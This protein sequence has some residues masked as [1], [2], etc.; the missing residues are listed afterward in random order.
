MTR[1]E[2]LYVP[3]IQRRNEVSAATTTVSVVG[4]TKGRHAHTSHASEAYSRVAWGS[5]Y[6]FLVSGGIRCLR[7]LAYVTKALRFDD[8]AD[9]DDDD[10]DGPLTT[11]LLLLAAVVTVGLSFVD[12]PYGPN[13]YLKGALC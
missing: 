2:A 11:L 4:K 12:N 3:K 1:L 9:E 13:D 7:S 5:W 6:V 10:N 8:A